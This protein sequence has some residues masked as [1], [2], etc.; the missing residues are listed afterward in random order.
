MTKYFI[1]VL[2]I[3]M[4]LGCAPAANTN[5]TTNVTV[6][7][8]T[9]NTNTAKPAENRNANA[10]SANA[11]VNKETSST[12]AKDD[13]FGYF[14]I[15]GKTPPEFQ[16]I[17][18]IN[19]GGEGEYGAGANPPF[20]GELA[21]EKKNESFKLMKP[22][23]S[24]NNIKFKTETKNGVSYEFE[25]T[26]KRKDLAENQ[27]NP[28]DV[29]MSGTLKKMENGKQIAESKLDFTWSVGD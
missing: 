14:F 10:N 11:S 17:S 12:T 15:T 13:V 20:Y 5:T 3:S 8:N 21:K 29:V 1:F 28:D 9:A 2:S 27:P 16:D 4:S 23:I 22:E 18:Y 7:T 19:L 6:N 24:G 26:L 25:G